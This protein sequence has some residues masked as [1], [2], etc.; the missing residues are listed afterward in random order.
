MRFSDR[1]HHFDGIGQSLHFPDRA[2]EKK[3]QITF[4]KV[5]LLPVIVKFA[6]WKKY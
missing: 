3:N 5:P 6:V 1:F 4:F 2:E